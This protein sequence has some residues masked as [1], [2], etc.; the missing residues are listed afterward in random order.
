MILPAISNVLT[1]VE[2]VLWI[3]ALVAF[4]RLKERASF[5]AFGIYLAISAVSTT[6]LTGIY[7]AD[8]IAPG[9]DG[10]LLYNFYFYT[11]WIT[12]FAG[13][14][15]LF[16]ALQDLFRHAMSS[17]PGLSR[18]G[19]LGFRWVIVVSAL[20]AMVSVLTSYSQVEHGA[21]ITFIFTEIARSLCVLELCLLAFLL[22]SIRALHI[23][24]RS[25]IFGICLGFSMM[26]AMNIIVFA[27]HVANMYTWPNQISEIVTVAS[28]LTWIG[29]LALPEPVRKQPA[30]P[31]SASLSR[32]N[33]L[34]GELGPHV[35]LPVT[36]QGGFLQNVESVVD[37]V[38]A[39]NSMN[40]AG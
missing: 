28:L 7:H 10:H 32:W 31:I 33:D 36:P 21:R 3:L 39:K 13:Y 16:L 27:L 22:V 4:L 24:H 12:Q 29:Y 40:N 23:D 15:A 35:P 8:V 19:I 20:V 37:R 9:L 30:A 18:L 2:P 38:L 34:A 14:V 26:A 1:S 6:L 5:G 25:R 17:L 11:Y